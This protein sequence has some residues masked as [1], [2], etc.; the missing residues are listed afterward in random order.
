M[1]LEWL[2]PEDPALDAVTFGWIGRQPAI[3]TAKGLGTA[4]ASGLLRFASR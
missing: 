2:L 4:V 1:R 3:E